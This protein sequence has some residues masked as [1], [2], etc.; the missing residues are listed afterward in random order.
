MNIRL[1]PEIL[2]R[3]QQ[4]R[5]HLRRAV[6]GQRQGMHASLRKGYGLEFSEYKAYSPGDDFR[7][8]DWN[9]LAR[10]DKIYTR[11]YREEQ[12]VK[13][14]IVLDYSKSLHYTSL[15]KQ[16]A[17]AIA[18]VTLNSGDKV[19][20]LLP[21][22]AQSPWSS[23]PASYHAIVK[24]LESKQTIPETEFLHHVGRATSEM[25]V[26]GR[27]FVISDMHFPL[28][29]LFSTFEYLYKRNFEA[30]L[31]EINTIDEYR[32]ESS[33]LFVDSETS[34]EL[35]AIMT[36]NDFIRLRT[37]YLAHHKE[38]ERACTRYNFSHTD[39]PIKT[40]L[41]DALFIHALQGGVFS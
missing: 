26:P 7:S 15:P 19:S 18:Y 34:E 4:L 17:L 41:E 35:D 38:I 16:L 9:V 6:L 13:V 31:I 3:L 36:E 21:G 1:T 28:Q 5:I 8:I 11:Q 10:T 20:V 24:M 40:P 29:D 37:L 2:R 22:V 12:D 39:I 23:T 33:S 30:T 27:V 14:L 32:F 25:K